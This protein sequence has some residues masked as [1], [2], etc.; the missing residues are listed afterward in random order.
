ME[1]TTDKASDAPSIG[2]SGATGILPGGYLAKLLDRAVK[3]HADAAR[4]TRSVPPA[5]R[6]R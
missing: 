2:A 3:L 1:K 5:Q 4:V 6:P